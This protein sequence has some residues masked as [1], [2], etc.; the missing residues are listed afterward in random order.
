[1]TALTQEAYGRVLTA[2]GAAGD[3][4]RA[5]ELTAS[6]LRT[7]DELELVTIGDRARARG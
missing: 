5:R 3:A 1:M 6:A 4:E 7:A 2:R